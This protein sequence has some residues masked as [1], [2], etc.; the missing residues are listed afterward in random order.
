MKKNAKN[1]FALFDTTQSNIVLF[2]TITL[3]KEEL[4]KNKNKNSWTVLDLS[5]G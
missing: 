3:S 4:Q 5:E 1:A 2:R